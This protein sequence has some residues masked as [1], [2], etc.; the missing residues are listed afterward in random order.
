MFVEAR[1]DKRDGALSLSQ[2]CG[3][4]ALDPAGWNKNDGGKQHSAK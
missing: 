3:T 2:Y 4:I 1:E